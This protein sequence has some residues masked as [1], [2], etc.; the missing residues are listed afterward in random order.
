[1]AF[2]SYLPSIRNLLYIS[3][4]LPTLACL[5]FFTQSVT[6]SIILQVIAT[7][8]VR[9]L[10]TTYGCFYI[11]YY[12]SHLPKKIEG[13]SAGLI[14]GLGCLGKIAAPYSVRIAEDFHLNSMGIFGLIYFVV[15]FLPLLLLPNE[16]PQEERL[17]TSMDDAVK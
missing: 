3:A 14:E 16:P 11:T 1:M 15:G 10:I 8:A 7:A 13:T 6:Q 17:N 4:L 12:V 9:F 5:S 2:M